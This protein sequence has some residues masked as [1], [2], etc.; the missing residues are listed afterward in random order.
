MFGTGS[1]SVPFFQAR[2]GSNRAK[3][4][5]TAGDLD[6]KITV[7]SAVVGYVQEYDARRWH[8]HHRSRH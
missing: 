7:P 6:R 3:W 4:E 5:K 2:T 8:G 1:T